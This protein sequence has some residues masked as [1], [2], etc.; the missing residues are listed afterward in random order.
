MAKDD[1][2]M[3]R[4]TPPTPTGSEPRPWRLHRSYRHSIMNAA[5]AGSS[6][7]AVPSLL[8]LGSD[9]RRRRSLE[10][11]IVEKLP[12]PQEIAV[13]L[14]Q[15][16]L[17][18]DSSPLISHHFDLMLRQRNRFVARQKKRRRRLE[19]DSDLAQTLVA[20]DEHRLGSLS[21]GPR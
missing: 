4:C 18:A 16:G 14:G 2:P 1:P 5:R 6:A 13:D 11:K 12:S 3:H 15:L 21:A 7:C 10:G 19:T 20:D 17:C 8:R 9:E